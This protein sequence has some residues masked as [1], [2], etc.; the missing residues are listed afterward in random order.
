M[1]KHTRNIYNPETMLYEVWT[2]PRPLIWLIRL[3]IVALAVLL[4]GFYIFLYTHVFGWDLP[5]TAAVKRENARL[6][7]R[8]E[9]LSHRLDQYERVLEGI[10][11]RDDDVYRSIFGMRPA[12]AAEPVPV[13]NLK[14]EKLD[15]S[16]A[17]QELKSLVRRMDN[18]SASVGERV[19]SLSGMNDMTAN[20]ETRISHIPAVP[21]IRPDGM[22]HI[23]SYF[24]RRTDPIFGGRRFHEG[25]DFASFK[26]N[27]VY[28]TGDAVVESVQ[29]QFFG[30]GNMII[31]NHGFGYKTR[32]AHLKTIL[33]QEGQKVLRGEQIG[34]LGNSGKSTGPHLHYEVIY[35]GNH[36]NPSNFY[37]MQMNVEEFDAMVNERAKETAHA[38]L[39]STGDLLR[40]RKK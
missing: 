28:A 18:M 31:L 13:K 32:Y 33:V 40:R 2:L 27:K 20:V 22:V 29:Y 9:L 36:V 1:F 5:K 11:R 34:E 16:G 12:S 14:Y 24:G 4:L 15:E 3:G 21:P 7:S 17:S 26:G 10:E 39:P 37:D 35:L 8:A 19:L 38:S 30:Y 25:Q 6:E 23:S